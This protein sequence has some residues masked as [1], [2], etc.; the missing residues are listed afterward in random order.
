MHYAQEEERAAG[1]QHAVGTRVIPVRLHALAVLVPLDGRDGP[2]LRL[3]VEGGG[4][5][6]GYDQIR[7]VLHDPGGAV[8]IAWP[9]PCDVEKKDVS[10]AP[11]KPFSWLYFAQ[12]GERLLSLTVEFEFNG[13]HHVFPTNP[14]SEQMQTM[15][16]CSFYERQT[17][18]LEK[19]I[20][21]I[22]RINGAVFKARTVSL[23]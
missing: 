15:S 7:G 11:I 2:A 23:G 17:A 16:V 3:A 20:V 4:F 12:T 22:M 10:G 18:E 19:K 8:F 6:L 14:A 1:Q 21:I 5:P 9:G 13:R